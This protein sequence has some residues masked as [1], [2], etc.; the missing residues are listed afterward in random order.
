MDGEDIYQ[1]ILQIVVDQHSHSAESY[2]SRFLGLFMG[3][4]YVF[5]TSKYL[6]L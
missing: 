5:F 2:T 3:E 6:H 4:W 1:N